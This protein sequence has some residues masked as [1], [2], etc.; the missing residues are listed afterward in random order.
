MCEKCIVKSLLGEKNN[1][2]EENNNYTETIS[3]VLA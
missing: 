1:N 2:I 3:L